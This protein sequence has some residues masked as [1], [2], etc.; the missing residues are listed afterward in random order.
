MVH[1][2]SADTRTAS[3]QSARVKGQ[4]LSMSDLDKLAV[5]VHVSNCDSDCKCH[6]E[7][8]SLDWLPSEF[9]AALQ[10]LVVDTCHWLHCKLTR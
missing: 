2:N 10:R 8:L 5:S 3:G 1:Y 4:L 7:G 9:K 6:N